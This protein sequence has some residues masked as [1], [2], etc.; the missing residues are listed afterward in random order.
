MS[1]AGSTSGSITAST[2]RA[3]RASSSRARRGASPGRGGPRRPVHR[4]RRDRAVLRE[5]RPGARVI[6]SEV[7]ERAVACAR[8]NGIEAFDGDLFDAAPARPGGQVD[9]RRRRALRPDARAGAAAPR[10]PHLRVR[11]LLRRRRDGRRSCAARWP[12]PRAGCAAAARCCSSSA[13]TRPKR[14]KTTSPARLHDVTTFTTRTATSAAR[15]DARR[16]A[17]GPAA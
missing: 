16:L 13:A 17:L 14:S 15:G 12:A 1:S 8:A 10:H 6:A 5:S 9:V 7:D 2:S 11:A 4:L 3:G